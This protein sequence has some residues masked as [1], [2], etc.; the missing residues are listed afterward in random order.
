MAYGDQPSLTLEIIEWA[1][2]S[3]FKV[4]QL[5]KVQNICLNIIIL[6]QNSLGSLRLTSDEAEKAGMNSKMFNS[7]LRN[8]IFFRDVSNSMIWT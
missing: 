7:F 5:E 3:G 1:R 6:L 4:T 2:A 8:E